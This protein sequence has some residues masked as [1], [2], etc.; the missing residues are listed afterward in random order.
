MHTITRK[1]QHMLTTHSLGVHS[2]FTS[3][4]PLPT[5]FP[6]LSPSNED[7]NKNEQHYSG[8]QMMAGV[9][10]CARGSL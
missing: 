7:K 4:S 10:D 1:R 8:E 9:V 5:C 6:F 3:S 2:K